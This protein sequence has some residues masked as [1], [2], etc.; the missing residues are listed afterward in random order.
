MSAFRPLFILGLFLLAA[1]SQ[2]V[3]SLHIEHEDAEGI[4][5]RVDFYGADN[6]K[7]FPEFNVDRVGAFSSADFFQE[8]SYSSNYVFY[9]GGLLIA[10][11]IALVALK[12]YFPLLPPSIGLYTAASGALVLFVPYVGE[13]YGGFIALAVGAYIFVALYY[14]FKPQP[15]K[16]AVVSSVFSVSA[17]SAKAGVPKVS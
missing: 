12:F 6:L 8:R 7:S 16:K 10:S 2:R 17:S 11:G 5:Q 4:R 15:R 9:I 14:N 3:S 1:C 13:R